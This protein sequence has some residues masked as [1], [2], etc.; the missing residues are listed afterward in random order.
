MKLRA[1]ISGLLLLAAAWSFAA[2]QKPDPRLDKK[3]T[4]QAKGE[5]L[6]RVLRDLSLETGVSM[7]CGINSN[8]WQVRDRKVIISVKEMPIRDLQRALAGLLHFTWSQ[9]EKNNEY[10]YRLYQ[11]ARQRKE[12]EDLRAALRAEGPNR[13]RKALEEIENLGKLKPNDIKALQEKSPWLYFLATDPTGI[14]FSKI[15]SIPAVKDSVIGS[16][17]DSPTGEAPD[18]AVLSL[19]P[20]EV[21]TVRSFT[22]GFA[23]I[24]QRMSNPSM[25]L[26]DFEKITQDPSKVKIEVKRFH[27]DGDPLAGKVVLAFVEV[28]VEGMNSMC[29]L[30]ILDSNSHLADT[31]GRVL[32][33]KS[34][35]DWQS[36]N[37]EVSKA[38]NA[39]RAILVMMEPLPD[40]PAFDKK[41]KIEV[42]QPT[43]G[44]L[45]IQVASTSDIQIISDCFNPSLSLKCG[46]T[47]VKDILQSIQKRYEKYISKNDN[48]LTL[49][50]R[51]W[52]V[53]RTWEVPE[54]SLNYW[55]KQTLSQKL[56]IS[57]LVDMSLLTSDQIDHTIMLGDKILRDLPIGNENRAFLHLYAKLSQ[58]QIAQLYDKGLPVAWLNEDQLIM[59]MCAARWDSA[60]DETEW[61]RRII[62]CRT[63]RSGATFNFSVNK[64]QNEDNTANTEEYVSEVDFWSISMPWEKHIDDPAPIIL[65]PTET[66]P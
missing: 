41:I 21:E 35:P 13:R 63:S 53:K 9:S 38:Q 47:T 24:A 12:E 11:S 44:D 8:D 1:I 22:K 43:L 56:S 39:D 26:P 65:D 58:E 52:F 60:T 46:G 27:G 62:T 15:L 6:Y 3:V 49:Q 55:R 25:E 40:D 33:S 37:R 32:S 48:L 50:D 31:A 64:D 42:T 4:Y 45:L 19:S 16:P 34:E 29:E 61:K 66:E 20:A 14:A 51:E 28:S 23:T 10:T 7:A 54:K 59:L 57:D 5:L 30:P 18:V 36:A 17:D 2:E